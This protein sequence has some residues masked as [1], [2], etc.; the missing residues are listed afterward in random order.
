[1]ICFRLLPLVGQQLVDYCSPE[2][3][4]SL[5]SCLHCLAAWLA[6]IRCSTKYDRSSVQSCWGE[7]GQQEQSSSA[8]C[9]ALRGSASSRGEQP[10]SSSAHCLEQINSQNSSRLPLHLQS[11]CCEPK[12]VGWIWAR[13]SIFLVGSGKPSDH[14][15]GCFGLGY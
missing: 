3:E 14:C 15:G 8:C 10:M 5:N 13:G 11:H 9:A 4:A 7:P 2:F 6:S 12:T 1:M